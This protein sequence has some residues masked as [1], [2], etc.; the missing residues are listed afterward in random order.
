MFTCEGS[1]DSQL[2]CVILWS[3]V[4]LVTEWNHHGRTFS[5]TWSLVHKCSTRHVRC[6]VGWLLYLKVLLLVRYI[7]LLSSSWWRRWWF[8]ITCMSMKMNMLKCVC[9][10]IYVYVV[11]CISVC[12]HS[13]SDLSETLLTIDGQVVLYTWIWKRKER[14]ISEL[15]PPYFFFRITGTRQLYQGSRMMRGIDNVLFSIHSQTLKR[16]RSSDYFWLISWWRD[17][18]TRIIFR[19]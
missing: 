14:L 15:L 17:N 13:V 12:V 9:K 1:A 2:P 3:A 16:T 7:T 5:W 19:K 18:S 8:M 4:W 6:D 11:I 10:C